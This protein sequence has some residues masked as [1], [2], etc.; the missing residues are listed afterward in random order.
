MPVL[1]PARHAARGM[2]AHAQKAAF[3]ARKEKGAFRILG[4]E[5]WVGTTHPLSLLHGRAAKVHRNPLFVLARVAVGE[6]VA[7]RRRRRRAEVEIA[8]LLLG[9]RERHLPLTGHA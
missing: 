6:V 3:A 4:G 2:S 5:A 8:R 1:P 9:R 7:P